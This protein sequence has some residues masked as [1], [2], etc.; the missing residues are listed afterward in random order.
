[1]AEAISVARP[2]RKEEGVFMTMLNV[3][4]DLAEQ[5]LMGSLGI[6][7]TLRGEVFHA[8]L[9]A[10]EWVQAVEQLPFKVVRDSV[11][12]ADKLTLAGVD[13]AEA[14]ALA[15]LRLVRGSGHAAGEIVTR[16]TESLVGAAKQAT[17]HAA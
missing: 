13:G 10:V 14:V 11:Q 16:T 9:G 6:A 7:R 15:F 4:A 12:R 8:A 17:T 3:G 1:M 2:P 5:G